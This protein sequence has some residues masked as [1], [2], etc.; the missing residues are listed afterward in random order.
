MGSTLGMMGKYDEAIESFKKCIQ[1]DPEN[2]KAHEFLGMTY[3]NLHRDAEAK[4]WFEKA[5]VLEQKKRRKKRLN[6]QYSCITYHDLIK[7]IVCL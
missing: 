2:A 7:K 5:A 4:P 1:F 6:K 3:K